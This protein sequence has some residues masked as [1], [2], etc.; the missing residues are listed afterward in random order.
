MPP[1]LVL[2]CSEGGFHVAERFLDV[3]VLES[4]ADADATLPSYAEYRST[5]QLRINH[6]LLSHDYSFLAP[7]LMP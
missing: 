3:F 4:I 2:F 6:R 5:T 7:A 1:G